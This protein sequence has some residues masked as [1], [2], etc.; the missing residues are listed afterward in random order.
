MGLHTRD[1]WESIIW[2]VPR[3]TLTPLGLKRLTE[4]DGKLVS[5][6]DVRWWNGFDDWEN[7]ED[8]TPWVTLAVSDDGRDVVVEVRDYKP[9]MQS[10][11][12]RSLLL[13]GLQAA[14]VGKLDDLY[15]EN[16]EANDMRDYLA[17]KFGR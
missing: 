1:I 3:D 11:T 9:K 6:L 15:S 8:D 7:R 17:E 4:L 12:K 10:H 14:L 5:S 2:R 13:H 16:G